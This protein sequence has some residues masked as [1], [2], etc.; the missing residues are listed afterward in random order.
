MINTPRIGIIGDY[1]PEFIS[2]QAT[3]DSL[4]HAAAA[5]CLTII[6]EWLPTEAIAKHEIDLMRFDGFWCAPGS[7]YR[8]FEGALTAIRFAREQR[9][10]FIGTCGGF[11]HTLLEFGR[12]VLGIVDAAHEEVTPDAATL[13]INKLSCSLVGKTGAIHLIAD[14]IAHD[15]YKTT[16]IEEQFRCNYGLNPLYAD[17]FSR[18]DLCITGVGPEGEA[19]IVELEH[20]PFFV[21][22]LFL[23]QLS[24][25]AEMPH[26][27]IFRY[28]LTATDNI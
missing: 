26:P 9:T 23:P 11:Q 25:T 1:N 21:A 2:H 24:S 8:H 22:T 3:M 6:P 10:P 28:L 20:H 4:H 16:A 13:I 5:L 7:P 27:L 15:V 19:R 18:H 12:N 17:Q 14:S